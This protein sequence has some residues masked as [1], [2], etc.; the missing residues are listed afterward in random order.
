MKKVETWYIESGDLTAS[1]KAV[2]PEQA[3]LKCLKT[4]NPESLGN[5]YRASKKGFA[6]R[7]RDAAALWCSTEETLKSA[8]LLEK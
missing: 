8:G 6:G 4:A 7:V 1:T 2:T 5:L 3:F